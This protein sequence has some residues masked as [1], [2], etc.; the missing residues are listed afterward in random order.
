MSRVRA[1]A[2]E[3]DPENLVELTGVVKW[4]D[5]SRGFGFIA[6]DGGG[7]D[8]LLH[9]SRVR[10]SMIDRVPDGALVR[11]SSYRGERGLQAWRVIDLQPPA[12]NDDSHAENGAPRSDSPPGPLEPARVKWFDKQRGFGFVNVLGDERDVFVH[13]E[14]LRQCNFNDL[15][16]GEAVLIRVGLSPRGAAAEDVVPW[17]S[18]AYFA[19]IEGGDEPQGGDGAPDEG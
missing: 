13:M 16:P 18:P 9:A 3:E 1:V 2:E 12:A 8:I 15:A 6:Q 11:V 17:N 14:T 10:A 5:T 4:Y 19:E 7:E